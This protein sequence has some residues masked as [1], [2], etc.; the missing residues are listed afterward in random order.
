MCILLLT[1]VCTVESIKHTSIYYLWDQF[2]FL[3]V[4]FGIIIPILGFIPE[5]PGF[6]FPTYFMKLGK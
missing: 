3:T 6:D 5:S 4:M 2:G 1:L